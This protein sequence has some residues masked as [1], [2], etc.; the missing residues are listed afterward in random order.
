M[1]I[2]SIP[3]VA[4]LKERPH[5]IM[6]EKVIPARDPYLQ[7]FDFR[8]QDWMFFNW[9][10]YAKSNEAMLRR[11]IINGLRG[12]LDFL[13]KLAKAHG[14]GLTVVFQPMGLLDPDNPFVPQSVRSK[15]GY[16]FL[17]DIHD[18]IRSEI[19][20]GTL[21]MVDLSQSLLPLKMHKFV[22]IAHYTPAANRALAEA[23]APLITG[24]SMP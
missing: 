17:R 8:E 11:E 18:L 23:I 24:P 12:N 9:E 16:R 20:S 10:I 4:Y 15:Y 13:E 5:Q 3:V 6:A 21:H 1:F 2:A 14:F 22:D 7:G 19:G